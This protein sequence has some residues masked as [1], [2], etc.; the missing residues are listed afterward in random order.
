MWEYVPRVYSIGPEVARV[1]PATRIFHALEAQR[2]HLF[3]WL[4]VCLGAGI[5]LYFA[6]GTEPAPGVLAAL[7]ALSGL[8]G[9][10]ALRLPVLAPA[11]WGVAVLAAG[12]PLSAMHTRAVAAPVLSW[13]YYGPI[14]G[15]VIGIDRSA[16]DRVRLTLDRVR[17][18]RVPPDR[19]PG[20]VRVSLHG[21]AEGWRPAPGETVMLTGH[22]SP[23]G[24]PVEPGGFDFQ[25]HAW[26][27]GIGAVG[28]TRTPVVTAVPAETG[29]LAPLP[30]LRL[31]LHVADAVRAA[32]PGP[33][34]AFAAAILTGDRSG[35]GEDTLENL[36]RANL[37]HLLAISGLHMGLLTGVVFAA[38]RLALAAVPPL[39]LRWPSK[40]LAAVGAMGAGA[41]YLALSGGNVATERAFVMVAVALTAVIF[42]RR[43]LTL[44]AV[45]IA[46]LIVMI[47]RPDSV[48]GPG[49][50]MSFAATAALVGVFSWM[51]DREG[52]M[53]PR[54]ARPVLAVVISSAV[55]GAATAPVAAAH[56]NRIADYGLVANLLSVPLMGTVVMPAAVL[57]AVLAPF[58]LGWVG[59]AIMRPPIAWI[60][61]VADRVGGAEGAVT[62]VVTPPAAVLPL[63]ALGGA[64]ILLWQGR[65]RWA[66]LAP[67]A[68]GAALWS[69]ADRPLVLISPDAGLFGVMTPEGRVLNRARG[70][71]FA[72]E[73]WLENDGDG[74]TQAGA[75]ARPG[76]A[77]TEDGVTFTVAG[78]SIAH[79]SGRD[80]EQALP[81]AC[82]T[83]DVVILAAEAPAAALPCTVI[84]RGHLAGTGALGLTLR[85][86]VPTWT[87]AQDPDARRPW[88][89]G[90]R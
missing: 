58:G 46:A 81:R 56:F 17:L 11:F 48:T 31:R 64:A 7:A 44:R 54:W 4:P 43:A 20:K 9:L 79:L 75:H 19:R 3:P 84:D 10:M 89:P 83:H 23:P 36:R 25:R 41:F 67:V 18:D 76:L 15:R 82:A 71:G 78:L 53:P 6:L 38:F 30:L 86:G 72:A 80:A 1:A 24:G 59:L 52:W 60:L 45:A 50:Q 70:Q 33:T 29:L 2:G 65:G 87:P 68:L 21:A 27:L 39:A 34:G 22:L 47:L 90:A 57:A 88:T 73:V 61:G 69:V 28:Y 37:A 66:G 62:H 26:F 85:K 40:K 13:H 35:I 42:D 55:A 14:E 5:C 63:M 16:S 12:L 49:F 77:R 51:R 8:A 74:A 32:M